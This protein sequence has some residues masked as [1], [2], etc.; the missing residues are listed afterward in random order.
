MQGE[1]P[2]V[3]VVYTNDPQLIK[4]WRKFLSQMKNKT[5]L[6]RFLVEEWQTEQYVQ[7]IHRD[8]KELY[9][10]C[11]AI[12]V[13]VPELCSCQEEADTR[14]LLHPAHAGQNGYDYVVIS[15]EDTDVFVLLLFPVSLMPVFS[16]N[17]ALGHAKYWLILAKW[18]QPSVKIFVAPLLDFI[19]SL[20]VR[21]SVP[22]L[23]RKTWCPKDPQ[24]RCGCKTSFH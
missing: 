16:R 1:E 7:R 21:Q 17:V 4:Q 3:Q 12:S 2:G 5:T 23:V 20:D 24:V 6:I 10:T 19:H 22:L 14:L 11:E 13:Q 15:S 9:V 8:G 18:W